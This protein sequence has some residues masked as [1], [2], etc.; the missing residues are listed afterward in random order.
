MLR[1]SSRSKLE[2]IAKPAPGIVEEVISQD[3]PGRVHWQGTTW[4]ARF[5]QP[6]YK[7]TIAAGEPVKVIAVLG[8][9]LLVMPLDINPETKWTGW[10]PFAGLDGLWN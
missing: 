7:E 6:D 10:K 9:T 3:S 4:P 5:F 2:K 1:F 8:I